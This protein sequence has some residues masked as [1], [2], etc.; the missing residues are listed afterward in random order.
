[1]SDAPSNKA[2]LDFRLPSELKED[3]EQAAIYTGQSLTD[4]AISAMVE[5]ARGIIR[6]NDA[7]V[8]SNR[9]RDAFLKILDDDSAE[10]N[11]SLIA[12]AK[13]YKE[14]NR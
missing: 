4:F 5:K 1:M 10:P 14:A 13:Q 9:D 12:A 3:I 8:L 6:E 7:T 11:E 2:R